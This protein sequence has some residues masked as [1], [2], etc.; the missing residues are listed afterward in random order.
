VLLAVALIAAVVARTGPDGWRF[1]AWAAATAAAL[2]GLL[3]IVNV[4]VVRALYRQVD[5]TRKAAAELDSK[6]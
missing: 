4:A 5:E 3:A 6:S 1:A 2:A